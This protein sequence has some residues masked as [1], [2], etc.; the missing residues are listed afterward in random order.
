MIRKFADFFAVAPAILGSILLA[1]NCG[2]AFYGYVCFFISSVASV[3]L[4][5]KTKDAPKSLLMLNI[6]FVAVNAFGLFRAI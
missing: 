1:S 2:L 6:F 5:R 3:Y 4:L